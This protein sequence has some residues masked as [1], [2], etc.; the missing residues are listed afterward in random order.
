MAFEAPCAR[1]EYCLP[2][3]FS[4]TFVFSPPLYDARPFQLGTVLLYL[5]NFLIECFINGFFGGISI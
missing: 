4:A 1:R 5:C 3:T 2:K